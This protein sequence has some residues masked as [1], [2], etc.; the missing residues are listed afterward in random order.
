MRVDLQDGDRAMIGEGLEE[1][2]GYRV[3]AAN[4]ERNGA[5]FQYVACAA[6]DQL[7]IAD[8]VARQG[9]QVAEIG[10]TERLAGKSCSKVEVPGLREFHILGERLAQRIAG[11]RVDAV[12]DLAIRGAVGSGKNRGAK[13]LGRRC[14]LCSKERHAGLF[15]CRTMSWVRM[16]RKI[17]GSSMR[18]RAI[19]V[20]DSSEI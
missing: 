2:D 8:A 15:H 13:T 3:V 10:A 1:G 19:T 5:R 12:V 16:S 4:H 18:K 17:L 9:R 6:L 20:N 14:G 7:A 11:P